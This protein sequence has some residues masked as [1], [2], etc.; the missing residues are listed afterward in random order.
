M[1]HGPGT[2]TCA[3]WQNSTKTAR[4]APVVSMTWTG[5]CSTHCAFVQLTLTGSP[6]PPGPCWRYK[7]GSIAS[8]KWCR[9][10][11]SYVGALNRCSLIWAGIRVGNKAGVENG[12]FMCMFSTEQGFIVDLPQVNICPAD[13]CIYNTSVLVLIVYNTVIAVF[14]SSFSKNVHQHAWAIFSDVS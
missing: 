14:T 6:P 2:H 9:H 4:Y 5:H 7:E 11:D 12:N 13:L 1:G 8:C 3:K 10:Q